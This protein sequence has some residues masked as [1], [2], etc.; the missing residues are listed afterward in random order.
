MV[1]APSADGMPE[2]AAAPVDLACRDEGQGPPILLLHGVGGNHTVWN[3]ILPGLARD[4]RVIAPDLRGHG[5]SPA[6]P[7]SQYTFLELEQDVVR[8]LDRKEVLHAHVVGFSGGAMLALRWA[9][10]FPDRTR[11]LVMV[12]GA[13]YTDAHTRSVAERWSQTYVREGADPFAL[14]LLKDLYYPDWIEAHLDFADALRAEVKRQDFTPAVR[15]ARSMKTF[16]ERDRIA[17]LHVPTLIVQAMDDA[18]VD[19]SHGRI[20]RQSIAGSQIRILAET[21]H[22]VPVERPR[23]TTEAVSAFVRKVEESPRS[24]RSE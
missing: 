17:T 16:D 23:E 21:G 4:H 12:S 8:L 19:A 2:P 9:L 5:R 13:A 7:E 11:S 22:I 14:R 15:W 10:D 3:A 20:L 1:S 24:L 18:V 6:P